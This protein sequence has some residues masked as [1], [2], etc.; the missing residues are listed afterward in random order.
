MNK[1]QE[2]QEQLNK[3]QE[4]LTYLR[5]EQEKPKTPKRWRADD[6]IMY[7][8]IIPNGEIAQD[9]EECSIVDNFQYATGNYFRTKK[10]AEDYK[11]RLL[12]HQELKDIALE[13]NN[14]EEI[15]WSCYEQSKYKL[16]VN[17]INNTIEY[18]CN[19]CEKDTS[20]YCLRN[21][22]VNVATERIGRDRLKNYLMKGI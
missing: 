9:K 7:Y 8:R 1:I 17:E 2:L 10:E 16:I 11:D 14:G 22:F 15:D 13:L 5:A 12:V 18:I 3:I 21:I 6:D 20:I 4:E 19:S